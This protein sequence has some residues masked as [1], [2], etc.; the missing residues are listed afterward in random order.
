MSTVH[1]GKHSITCKTESSSSE[2]VALHMGMFAI[3]DEKKRKKNPYI[4]KAPCY[5]GFRAT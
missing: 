2:I 1:G 3:K 4:L 5:S